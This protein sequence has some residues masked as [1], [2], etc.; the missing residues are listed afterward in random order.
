MYL[1]GGQDQMSS[2]KSST[3]KNSDLCTHWI[4]VYP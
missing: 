2:E 4:M 1:Y 3:V